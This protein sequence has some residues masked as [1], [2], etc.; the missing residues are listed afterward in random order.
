[1]LSDQILIVALSSGMVWLSSS[2]RAQEQ[3]LLM[4]HQLLN[5]LLVGYSPDSSFLIF[6]FSSFSVAFAMKYKEIYYLHILWIFNLGGFLFKFS[7]AFSW[8]VTS[9]FTISLLSVV[10]SNNIITWI[11]GMIWEF[12]LYEKWPKPKLKRENREQGVEFGRKEN[13]VVFPL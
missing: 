3:E 13:M 12:E 1:M 5:W 7:H 11:E 6:S 10:N 9:V 4:L 8:M 2:H